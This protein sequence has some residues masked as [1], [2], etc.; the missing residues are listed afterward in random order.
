[1]PLE[2][3]LEEGRRDSRDR[4]VPVRYPCLTCLS[5]ILRPRQK[6]EESWSVRGIDK[7]VRSDAAR[8]IEFYELLQEPICQ[9]DAW[10]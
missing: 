2:A 4:V 9:H 7:D 10:R 6:L 1:M 8:P 5:S 3:V